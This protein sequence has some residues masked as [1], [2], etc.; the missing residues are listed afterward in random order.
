MT[1]GRRDYYIGPEESLW[2]KDPIPGQTV[3]LLA[4]FKQTLGAYSLIK[5]VTSAVN[6]MHT[7]EIDDESAYL[8]EGSLTVI[9]GDRTYDLEPGGFVYMP[10]GIPH[11]FKPNGEIVVLNIQAPGGVLDS[12]IED[13]AEFL[14][15]GTA[16]SADAY[17]EMQ[18]KHGIH[19]PDGW[20][21]YPG[22]ASLIPEHE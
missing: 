4:G 6:P 18:F 17:Q 15:A 5:C 22:A 12:M 21:R 1:L 10:R 19:A 14:A 8:L 20:Y 2:E 16:L 11:Q 9:V 7:H 3:R 13:M